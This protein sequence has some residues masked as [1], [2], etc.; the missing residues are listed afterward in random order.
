M[1]GC[2][3]RRKSGDRRYSIVRLVS[4]FRIIR[5]IKDDGK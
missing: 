2:K 1:L 3:G 5:R 4:V